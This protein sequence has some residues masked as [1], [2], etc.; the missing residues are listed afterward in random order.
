MDLLNR[1]VNRIDFDSYEDFD[2]DLLL[3]VLIC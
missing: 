2:R 1:F 3:A